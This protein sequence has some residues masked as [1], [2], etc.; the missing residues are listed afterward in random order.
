MDNIEGRP[1]KVMCVDCGGIGRV[2]ELG[3]PRLYC[4]VCDGTGSIVRGV[5][6]EKFKLREE[7]KRLKEAL[8]HIEVNSNDKVAVF[9]ANRA[10]ETTT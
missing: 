6:N 9:I 2:V 8:Q 4:E 1:T 3:R 5:D 7:N 10:L